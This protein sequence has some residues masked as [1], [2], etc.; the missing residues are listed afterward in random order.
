MDDDIDLSNAPRPPQEADPA[1]FVRDQFQRFIGKHWRG[2]VTCPICGS[3][4]WT[5]GEVLDVALRYQPGSAFSLMPVRCDVCSYTMFF[6]AVSAG[7]F[8]TDGNPRAWV[9]PDPEPADGWRELPAGDGD[10]L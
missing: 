6:N 10:D 5:T 1:R 7:L 4:E 8:D 9:D 3:Y 2:Y